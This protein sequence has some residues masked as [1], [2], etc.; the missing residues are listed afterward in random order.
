MLRAAE[1]FRA[2]PVIDDRSD[3]D[4]LGYGPEGLPS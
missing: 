2:L 4:I 3:E 1:D